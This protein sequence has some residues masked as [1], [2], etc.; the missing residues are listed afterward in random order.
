MNKRNKFT[1][2]TIHTL[3]WVV[4]Y[5][6][7]FALSTGSDMDMADIILHFWLQLALIG[8]IF[9]LNYFYLIDR[10]LFQSRYVLL[11]FIVNAVALLSMIVLKIQIFSWY[12]APVEHQGGGPPKQLTWYMDFLMY[13]I[14]V[15]I[16]I[17]IKTAKRGLKVESLKAEAEN[18]RLQSELQHLKFQFQPHF[19]FNALNNVYSLIEIDPIKAQQ[20]LHSLSRLMRHLMHTSDAVT[21]TLEE[22][23]D[24]LLKYIQIME[25]R[26]SSNVEV[27][28]IFPDLLPNLKIAPLLFIT[29]VENAFKHGVAAGQ[30]S[31]IQF[32]LDVLGNQKIR[33]TASN[34]L[35]T[36]KEEDLSVSGIGLAN[37]QKRLDILYPQNYR[38]TNS[39][40]D[41]CYF[42]EL[43]LCPI[44]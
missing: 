7:P 36:K 17:A 42:V 38:L 29:M 35:F 22:E 3:V 5:F 6:L 25:L 43:E 10:C 1:E 34:P 32:E 28:T 9:Y 8:V 33:F 40:K 26:M 44:S 15:A 16:S 24:F 12:F 41:N 21:I 20:S 19:V 39:I 23:V 18:I 30:A 37:L 2:V 11:F 31:L 13:L 4:L 14:P 27:R